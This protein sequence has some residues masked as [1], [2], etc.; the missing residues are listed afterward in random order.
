MDGGEWYH[1]TS[2]L[3]SHGEHITTNHVKTKITSRVA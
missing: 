1:E 3:F 2:S